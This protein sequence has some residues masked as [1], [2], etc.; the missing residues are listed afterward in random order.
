MNVPPGR[1]NKTWFINLTRF[2]LGKQVDSKVW[3]KRGCWGGSGLEKW[4]DMPGG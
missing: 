2:H 1:S 4:A 3:G